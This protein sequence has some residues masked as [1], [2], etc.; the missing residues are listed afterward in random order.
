MSRINR[1]HLLL[2]VSV[3]FILLIYY[4]I[5]EM[6]YTNIFIFIYL[7]YKIQ[8]YLLLALLNWKLGKCLD[9]LL[10]LK[11]HINVST[12]SIIK[13]ILFSLFLSFSLCLIYQCGWL[14]YGNT[15]VWVISFSLLVTRPGMIIKCVWMNRVNSPFRRARTCEMRV[16]AF[17]APGHSSACTDEAR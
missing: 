10:F 9:L 11:K 5:F 15:F 12:I 8:I 16:M 6:F 14:F 13:I 17:A 3:I 2:L 4:N 7:L 1:Y